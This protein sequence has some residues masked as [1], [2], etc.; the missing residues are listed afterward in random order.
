MSYGKDRVGI[1]LS[2]GKD[3]PVPFASLAVHQ[4]FRDEGPQFP[5]IGHPFGDSVVFCKIKVSHQGLGL[6]PP[7]PGGVGGAVGK[8]F[9]HHGPVR[10][11]S[12]VS[13]VGESPAPGNDSGGM[14]GQDFRTFH[15]QPRCLNVVAV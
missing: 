9:V 15:G 10:K 2:V 12:A 14:V 4:V 11:Q 5:G 13:G 1:G 3:G 8:G 6:H 7:L